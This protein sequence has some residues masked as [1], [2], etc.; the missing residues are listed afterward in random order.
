MGI[1]VVDRAAGRQPLVRYAAP[2]LGGALLVAC[3]GAASPRPTSSVGPEFS[4]RDTLT[5]QSVEAGRV[6]FGMLL[7]G[8]RMPPG[9][10]AENITAEASWSGSDWSVWCWLDAQAG[11]GRSARP[12]SSGAPCS[13]SVP[14]ERRDFCAGAYDAP[15]SKVLDPAHPDAI[16]PALDRADYTSMAPYKGWLTWQVEARPDCDSHL[17]VTFHPP[18]SA[19]DPDGAVIGQWTSSG[20]DAAKPGAAT[21]FAERLAGSGLIL[22][23]TFDI[24]PDGALVLRVVGPAEPACHVKVAFHGPFEIIPTTISADY[25]AD[26]AGGTEAVELPVSRDVTGQGSR[27]ASLIGCNGVTV[28]LERRGPPYAGT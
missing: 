22:S 2:L 11:P 10:I 16:Q 7:E 14:S 28:R 25:T 4:V 12:Y 23:K 1:P 24:P 27:T 8:A 9:S 13:Q 3:G 18:A 15:T 5:K 21:I 17:V 6:V 19:A 26:L 20:P